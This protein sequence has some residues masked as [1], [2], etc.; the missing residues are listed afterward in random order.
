M[1][2]HHILFDENII[3]SHDGVL[4]VLDPS[5]MTMVAR[6]TCH[7]TTMHGVGSTAFL[8]DKKLDIAQYVIFW[9]IKV[10]INDII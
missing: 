5:D 7:A 1:G 2:N 6:E 9:S 8:H 4:K 3:F 10:I